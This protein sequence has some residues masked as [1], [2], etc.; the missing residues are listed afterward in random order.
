MGGTSWAFFIGCLANNPQALVNINTALTIPLLILSGF[1]ANADNF[2]PYLIPIK[3][4]SFFKY[5]FQTV[6]HNEFSDLQP[7]NCQNLSGDTCSP[8]ANRFT[9]LEPFYVTLILIAALSVFFNICSFLML[10]FFAKIRV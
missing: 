7:L 1:F 5:G 9:F 6:V 10:Y 8:M 2:A 3:Y 4:L